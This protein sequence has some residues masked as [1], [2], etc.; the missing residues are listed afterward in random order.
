MFGF[1]SDFNVP[2]GNQDV[3][4]VTVEWL[5]QNNIW[6]MGIKFQWNIQKNMWTMIGHMDNN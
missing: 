2:E 5:P 4:M 3:G 1:L 6:T